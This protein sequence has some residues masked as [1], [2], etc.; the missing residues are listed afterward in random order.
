MLTLIKQLLPIYFIQVK[1]FIP[2]MN[3]DFKLFL[4]NICSYLPIS[5]M[6]QRIIF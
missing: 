5:T 6:F 4:L 3:V 2:D 1:P